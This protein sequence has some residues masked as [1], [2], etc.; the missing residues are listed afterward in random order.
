MT[1][2]SFGKLVWSLE[3]QTESQHEIQRDSLISMPTQGHKW[4]KK[5]LWN[6]KL[7]QGTKKKNSTRGR[8][9]RQKQQA[10]KQAEGMQAIH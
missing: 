1:G 8:D 3:E 4:K 2:K 5:Q 6:E 7:W 10:S 9:L